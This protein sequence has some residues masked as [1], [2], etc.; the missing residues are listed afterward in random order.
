M[1]TALL[2]AAFGIAVLCGFLL[3]LWIINAMRGKR[4]ATG[5]MA[6]T[7]VGMSWAVWQVYVLNPVTGTNLAYVL[8]PIAMPFTMLRLEVT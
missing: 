6:G 7:I 8:A 2:V 5:R 3:F 4:S 1:K